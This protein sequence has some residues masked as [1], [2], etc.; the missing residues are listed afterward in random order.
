MSYHADFTT[1]LKEQ[2]AMQGLN[3]KK[4]I[5]NEDQGDSAE[6]KDFSG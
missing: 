6:S 3:R 4:L 5:G 1:F 2:K